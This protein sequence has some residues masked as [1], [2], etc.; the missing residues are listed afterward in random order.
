MKLKYEINTILKYNKELE[1][2]PYIVGI[3]A[4]ILGNKCLCIGNNKN[5]YIFNKL[6]KLIQKLN[7]ISRY[8]Y[9][10]NMIPIVN[11]P[12]LFALQDDDCIHIY[13]VQ[14][15]KKKEKVKLKRRI[16]NPKNLQNKIFYIFS[17]SCADILYF[18]KDNFLIYDIKNESFTYKKFSLSTEKKFEKSRNE[19]NI[20]IIKI[21]EYKKNEL[22]ILLRE[23]L[24]GKEDLNYNCAI[25]IKN[26][27]VLF[28]LENSEVKK[29]YI[30]KE[31][32]GECN[33]Y[34]GSYTFDY[35][36]FS[37]DQNIFI[38]KNSIVYLKDYQLEYG[39]KINYSIYI[40][41]ILNGDIKY[42]FEGDD[43]THPTRQFL[44]LDYSFQ[45]SIH[46][47]DNIFLFNGYELMIK[48]NGVEQNKIDIIY[49]TNED[50]YE[51]NKYYYIKLKKN[52]L[53]LYNSHEIKICHFTK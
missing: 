12:N 50:I 19:N 8:Y 49:G 22:I 14:I 10:K 2:S 41:N 25:T 26:S 35:T 52:L 40:I 45:K 34:M 48:K 16:N 39:L 3:E 1:K 21:I 24:Y 9:A 6:Y 32:S 13:E 38:I 36:T 43:I 11:Y 29:V 46:L 20:Q 33:T 27:I 5:V 37:N 47:C 53:L 44:Y 42:E 30:T 4:I 23:I 15:K 18:F 17:L 51:N 28:D 31:D 7:I